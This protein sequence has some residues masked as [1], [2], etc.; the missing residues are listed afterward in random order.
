MRKKRGYRISGGRSVRI[1]EYLGQSWVIRIPPE[2]GNLPVTHIG[3]N[4]FPMA[5]FDLYMPDA[6][7]YIR[8]SVTI[9]DSVVYIGEMA[10]ASNPRLISV[11]VPSGAIIAANAFDS[12]VSVIRDRGDVSTLD[13]TGTWISTVEGVQLTMIL[14]RNVWTL[15]IPAFGLFSTGIFTITDGIN[16]IDSRLYEDSVHM[17]TAFFNASVNTVTVN[18]NAN[19]NIA[20]NHIFVVVRP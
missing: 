17:G 20:S 4:A 13:F 8:R 1:V 18:L 10:F 9:P 6:M 15:D 12:R 14:T 16:G 19:A 3:A 2:I 11:T 5:E 7:P